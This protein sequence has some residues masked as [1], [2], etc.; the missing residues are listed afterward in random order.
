MKIWIS[1][2]EIWVSIK[3]LYPKTKR[4]VFFSN[5]TFSFFRNFFRCSNVNYC[6]VSN[7]RFR[8]ELTS[9][10]LGING[11]LKIQSSFSN[12]LKVN[13]EF[14]EDLKKKNDNLIIHEIVLS[15]GLMNFKK[16]SNGVLLKG[17]TSDFL[18]IEKFF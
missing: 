12:G 5:H 1:F 13:K 9:K 8:E 18:K 10:I 4:K 7:E 15:Q 2:F 11:H 16:Y 17:V 6:N 14:S 3:Y